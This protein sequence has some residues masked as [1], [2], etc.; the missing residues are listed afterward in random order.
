LPQVRQKFRTLFQLEAH[1][2]EAAIDRQEPDSRPFGQALPTEEEISMAQPFEDQ[3]GAASSSPPAPLRWLTSKVMSR[4]VAPATVE[5]RHRRAERA[6]RRAVAPHRVEYFHQVEDGYGHLAAQLLR[7]LLDHYEVELV[8]HLVMGPRDRN[9]PEPDLLLPLSRYDSAKVAP[10]YGLSFPEGAGAPDREQVELAERILAAASQA[11]FPDLAVEV[12]DSLWCGDSDRLSGLAARA[13]VADLAE[14][15][16]RI[17][18][19]TDRRQKLG[20]YSGAMFHYGNEWYWGADR[21]HHLESRLIELGAGRGGHADLL[22][23]RP[24]IVKGPLSDDGS[25]TLEFYASLRSPYTS[26][27][28]DEVVGLAR[29]T[30]VELVMKPVL[31]MVMRGVPV[32]RNK[33]L[34]IFSDSAR[35]AAA[36]GLDW[37]HFRDPI[38]RP[39][40]NCYSLYPW[41]CKHG[42]GVELLGHFLRAAFFEGVNTNNDRG[43]RVVVEKAGLPWAEAKAIMGNHDFE[44]ELETNRLAMYEFG[45]WGVPSFRLLDRA[46]DFA[47]GLWGQDRLWLVARE[48]QRLLG[49]S[50]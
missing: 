10:H 47:L 26:V 19:G 29:E 4:L 27:I 12:G 22:C 28:Y 21:F 41:A 45:S 8:C 1:Y 39:A 38:G 7:P 5:R 37:G 6:R 48:I 33:G 34:Y 13:G 25:L 9:L 49:E 30:G 42:K 15:A 20:H 2:F 35:E 43:M 50:K 44:D 36:M 16:V 40:L 24:A 3:G 32:T 23:P 46:G 17:S 31:P 14:T 11:D 18:E